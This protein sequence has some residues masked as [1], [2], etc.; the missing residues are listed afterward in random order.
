MITRQRRSIRADGTIYRQIRR[1]RV[2]GNILLD[3][4]AGNR[5]GAS[6]TRGAGPKRLFGG[7]GGLGNVLQLARR[8][9]RFLLK[10]RRPPG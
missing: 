10:F 7:L 3:A 8:S 9:L 4:G 2:A 1:Q 6:N 5:R